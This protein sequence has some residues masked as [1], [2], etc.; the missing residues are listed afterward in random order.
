[1]TAVDT[2][3]GG[4]A[5]TP[6][7]ERANERLKRRQGFL[8]ALPAYFY[9]FIFF[10]V[11]L[12]IVIVYSFATRTTS[13]TELGSW[14]LDSYRDLADPKILRILWR[15]TWYAL[16]TTFICLLIAYPFAYLHVD[17]VGDQAKPDARLRDDS[18]LDELPR[19]QLCLAGHSRPTAR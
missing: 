14:N 6:E 11:P 15:S 8:M 10:V 16:L 5:V 19:T 12:V 9:L 3:L 1:M 18:V 4:S 7:F 2:P 13:G 17:A